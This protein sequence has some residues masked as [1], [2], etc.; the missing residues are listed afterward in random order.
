MIE[1]IFKFLWLHVCIHAWKNILHI[2][3]IY[4]DYNITVATSGE[5]NKWEF[6]ESFHNLICIALHH[7]NFFII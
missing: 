4:I 5:G 2:L 7:I 1:F 6:M 3:N